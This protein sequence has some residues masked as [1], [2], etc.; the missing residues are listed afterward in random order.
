MIKILKNLILFLEFFI[1][2]SFFIFSLLFY[3][4]INFKLFSNFFIILSITT[5]ILKI[6][7]WYL[8]QKFESNDTFSKK[9]NLFFSR[10]S[11]CIFLYILPS[12]YILL[13]PYLIISDYIIFITF[14]IISVIALIST[15]LEKKYFINI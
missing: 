4:D 12:Y 1:L 15:I 5:F 10:L 11:I 14:L 13:Y 9:T 3:K 7:Y 6:I 8:I 2:I